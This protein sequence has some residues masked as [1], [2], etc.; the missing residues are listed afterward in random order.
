MK[1]A[2]GKLTLTTEPVRSIQEASDMLSRMDVDDS[3]RKSGV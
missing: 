1:E 3:D 2:K